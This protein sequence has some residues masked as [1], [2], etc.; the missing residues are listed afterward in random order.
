MMIRRHLR[1]LAAVVVSTALVAGAAARAADTDADEARRTL[2]GFLGSMGKLDFAAVAAGLA[3]KA[4]V[5]V[6]RTS[7]ADKGVTHLS[8]E[9]WIARLRAKNEPLE[10]R[11]TDV[12]VTT[13]GGALAAVR[14]SFEIVKG[15]RVES[16][17]I[18]HFELVKD[19]GV[20]KVAYIAFTTAPGP[21]PKAR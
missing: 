7:G 14:P 5:L 17:G 18:D 3:P 13:D 2:E 16:S 10:E 15:G 6:V 1:A 21:L 12:K 11:L 19:A 9:E 8:G 20:W 4:S